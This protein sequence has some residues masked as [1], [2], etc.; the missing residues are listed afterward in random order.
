MKKYLSTIL[1]VIT[2][3]LVGGVVFFPHETNAALFTLDFIG[4]PAI[5]SALSNI[6]YNLLTI[7]SVLVT[8]AGQ[9][10]SISINLTLH[11]KEIYE[12][13]SGIKSVWI[14]IRDISSMFIIFILLYYSILT[15]V[16]QSS[17]KI[18]E[19]IVKIFIAGVFINFS[20]FFVRVAVDMSNLVSLQFY[21]AI[22][23]GTSANLNLASVF[24]D[25]GLSNIFLQSLKV[26]RIYNTATVGQGLKAGGNVL[27]AT[28]LGMIIMVTAAF[29][30]LAAALAFMARVAI[31]LFVMAVSPLYF[32]GMIFPQVKKEVSD[33]IM[34][35]FTG[36]LIFMPVYL[37]LLYVA[38]RVISDPNF[39]SIF[40]Q[41]GQSSTTSYAY[42]WAGIII[43]YSIAILFIN[44]PLVAAIS[45]S[46]TKGFGMKWAPQYNDVAGFFG[47]HTIGR[48]AKA[49]QET[50]KNS[51]IAALMPGTMT[52]VNKALGKASGASFGGS[53]GGYDK[54]FKEYSEAR[55]KF[56]KDLGAS[57]GDKA[58]YA[59][60]KLATWTEDNASL[61]TKLRFAAADMNKP[62]LTGEAKK[63]A[64]KEVAKIMG[65]LRAREKAE[66]DNNRNSYLEDELVKQ[67]K[68]KFADNLANSWNPFSRAANKKASK[69]LKKEIKKD[70]DAAKA[71]KKMLEEA[72]G[73]GETPPPAAG[74]GGATGGGGGGGGGDAGTE[75]GGSVEGGGVA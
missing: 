68:E 69:G 52:T 11:I 43:Q 4:K 28:V 57:E 67:R 35:V 22:A 47:Q 3:L 19:L 66:K 8:A 54:R 45:L 48:G 6:S 24:N 56:G 10:L 60:G 21:N 62:G 33:K 27:T 34:K 2:I 59:E 50:L 74:G 53:K 73:G 44:I 41:V 20:L 42:V 25:G 12:T 72:E 29:S 39:N 55:E 75:H 23:P 63:K 64:E 9:F 5:D 40:S 14:T 32:A 30:L 16:G 70:K 65:E 36:Q 18:K 51:R 71:L 7:T 46:G 13:I 31:L 58:E 1:K 49:A 17:V 15:I 37:F 26:P 38:L 61:R